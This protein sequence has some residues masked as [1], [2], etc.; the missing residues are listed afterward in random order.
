MSIREHPLAWRWTDPKHVKFAPDVL[1]QIAPLDAFTAAA[2]HDRWMP[3]FDRYGEVIREHFA[4]IEVCSTEGTW[5]GDACS[6][7][8]LLI[9]QVADWLRIREPNLSLPVTISWQRDCAVRTTWGIFTRWWDDFCYPI[10]DDAFI[11]ADTPR[12]FL[13]F[14]H[15][16]LFSFCHNPAA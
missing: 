9:E 10:S 2:V 6:R 8:T 14:H 11:V 13:A 16:D 5:K 15:E 1:S 12:W 3:Y 4:S 7:Q